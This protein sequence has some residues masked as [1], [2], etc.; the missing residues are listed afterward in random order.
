MLS[1][2]QLWVFLPRLRTCW[3]PFCGS[4]GLA[5]AKWRSTWQMI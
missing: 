5:W 2:T 4:D 3:P 1:T